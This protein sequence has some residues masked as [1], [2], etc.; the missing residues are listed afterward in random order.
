MQEATAGWVAS[1]T[2][3]LEAG[4]YEMPYA[5]VY[6]VSSLTYLAAKAVVKIPYIGMVNILANNLIVKEFIQSEA[7]PGN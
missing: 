6:K 7:N 2:A 5:L 3:S 4:F 1:G